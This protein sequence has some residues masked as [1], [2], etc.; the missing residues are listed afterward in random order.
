MSGS[1]CSV[2]GKRRASEATHS[3]CPLIHDLIHP[4]SKIGAQEQF[5]LDM[6]E[7]HPELKT[8]SQL[9]VEMLS[10]HTR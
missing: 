2:F 6:F 9:L 3:F 8:A 5:T 7:Y 10:A 4:G 1:G